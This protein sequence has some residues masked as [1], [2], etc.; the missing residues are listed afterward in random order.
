MALAAAPGPLGGPAEA[1]VAGEAV[2]GGALGAAG[3][4]GVAAPEV[5]VDGVGARDL[6]VPLPAVGAA[7]GEERGGEGEGEEG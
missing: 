3:R 5:V 1:A 6:R 2:V 4:G 7:L